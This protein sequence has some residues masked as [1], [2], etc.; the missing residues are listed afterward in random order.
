L[1]ALDEATPRLSSLDP[2]AVDIFSVAARKMSTLLQRQEES[3]FH[4]LLQ[5][6]FVELAA[7]LIISP[8]SP[9]VLLSALEL[10]Y[11]FLFCPSPLITR[12]MLEKAN[13]FPSLSAILGFDDLDA[14]YFALKIVQ[15]N[16]YD[17]FELKIR[18]SSVYHFPFDRILAI[19][20]SAP[21]GSRLRSALLVACRFICDSERFGR[22]CL[23]IATWLTTVCDSDTEPAVLLP[24]LRNLVKSYADIVRDTAPLMD[25]L[26]TRLGDFVRAGAV[27]SSYFAL[28]LY[29]QCMESFPDIA[30]EL[31]KQ[32]SIEDLVLLLDSG[33]QKLV[34]RILEFL[35]LRC[36]DGDSDWVFAVL[37]DAHIDEKLR[38]GLL[39]GPYRVKRAVLEFSRLVLQHAIEP[40]RVAAFV[41]PD[42]LSECALFLGDDMPK[43]HPP[44][45]RF[46]EFVPRKTRE[47]D[48][49]GLAALIHETGLAMALE[50][51]A[52]TDEEVAPLARAVLIEFRQLFE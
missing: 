25:F 19:S 39:E 23:D 16:A 10:L 26:Q 2:E 41:N 33:D 24:V 40:E 15:L 5:S 31:A 50:S 7:N 35:A 9:A 47:G 44:I 43:L 1:Q 27:R 49:E 14:V 42:F 17:L 12:F 20:E 46:L 48:I 11:A 36:A 21:R 45:L 8:P 18:F 37:F 6:P 32:V 4:A 29:C 28:K 38:G 3:V 34:A 13:L 52:L 30:I 51:L 22:Y